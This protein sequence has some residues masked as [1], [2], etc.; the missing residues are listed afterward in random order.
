[1]SKNDSQY[2]VRDLSGAVGLVASADDWTPHGWKVGPEPQGT[3]MVWLEHNVTH[4]KALFAFPVVETWSALGWE[5]S[6][7]PTPKDLTKDENLVDP[8][9][10]PEAP[11]KAAAAV[12][13]K[14][15]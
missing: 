6:A 3:E 13:K 2:W 11:K 7:P 8:I 15:Q 9:P 1:M 4:G 14:E 5:P 12:A 10:A